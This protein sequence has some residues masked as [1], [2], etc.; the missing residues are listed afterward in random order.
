M[1]NRK[2]KATILALLIALLAIM[3]VTVGCSSTTPPD[4]IDYTNNTVVEEIPQAEDGRYYVDAYLHN[5]TIGGDSLIAL[6]VRNET[7]WRWPTDG[8]RTGISLREQG[9]E[10]PVTQLPGMRHIMHYGFLES[11]EFT[12]NPEAR[13]WLNSQPLPIGQT[14]SGV[15]AQLWFDLIDGEVIVQNVHLSGI[16]MSGVTVRITYVDRHGDARFVNIG[17]RSLPVFI[18][19]PPELG[20]TIGG[21]YRLP[22]AAFMHQPNNRQC[23]GYCCSRHRLV[24]LA[25][26]ILVERPVQADTD[27]A[28]AITETF[29]EWGADFYGELVS[30]REPEYGNPGLIYLAMLGMGGEELGYFSTFYVPESVWADIDIGRGN[31]LGENRVGDSHIVIGDALR[32]HAHNNERGG[33][34]F[35]LPALA[36]EIERI[37]HADIPGWGA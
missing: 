30:W 26:P 27:L 15:Q 37:N 17:G 31:S 4:D 28:L 18:P 25:E 23:S 36:V 22:R 14:V 10:F 16:D 13:F 33:G 21:Y 6:M 20:F 8:F 2:T 19:S 34:F 5:V 7:F 29:W 3:F 12:L 11:W 9:D 35:R 32:V 24:A 1:T